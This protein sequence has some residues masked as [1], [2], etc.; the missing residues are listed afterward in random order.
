MTV[1]HTPSPHNPQRRRLLGTGLGAAVL[2]AGLPAGLQVAR[3]QQTTRIRF[4]LDWR[5]DGPAA[6]FLAA[7]SKGYF[8]AENLDVQIDSGSGSGAAVNR[9][10]SG[11]YHM[12]FA[13][14]AALMEF[15]GNNPDAPN[16]PVGVM[17]L[18]N[19]TPATIFSLK[20]TGINTPKDLEGKKM[21]SPS[22]DAGR[23]AFPI[24]AQ[25]NHVDE[26][27]V[28]W[29]SMEP[30]LRETM[31][32]RGDVDAIT[33][34]YYTSFLNLLA[35]GVKEADI[36]TMP[37]PDYGVR[38]YGNAIIADQRFAAQNPQ[39]V[40]GFLRALTRATRDVL[41]DPEGHIALVKAR[42]G[43]IDTK[44][45]LR[46]LKM[47]L[48]RAVD[49]PDAKADGFGD[50]NQARFDTMALQVTRVYA[51]QTPVIAAEIFDRRYLP[52]AQERAGVLRL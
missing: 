27:R 52:S 7:V 25:T 18:Y 40:T 4:Q 3:A 32:A 50:I 16:K 48:E 1:F 44:T 14:I 24:F 34:F 9:V 39:A 5:F 6:L 51:T 15:H 11:A 26:S 23:R 36:V 41:A 29:I 43:I 10:A 38:L 30:A 8:K 37:Y 12:G 31:L 45:E 46:R 35:R 13:D 22:F 2:A 47:C 19:N 20:K 28:Q 33:G 42:D 49:T 17:M 21:G